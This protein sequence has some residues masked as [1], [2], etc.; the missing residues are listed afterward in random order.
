[1]K[2]NLNA[3]EINENSSGK[4][5]LNVCTNEEA[6]TILE[7]IRPTDIFSKE[8]EKWYSE[9]IKK[10]NMVARNEFIVKNLN[11]VYHVAKKFKNPE[12]YEDLVN[13]G[14]VGLIYAVDNF[15]PDIARFSTYAVKCISGY[16]YR[17]IENNSRL[18]R[19]PSY[20]HQRL[21][22]I[23]KVLNQLEQESEISSTEI[24]E[25]KISKIA[26]KTGY[27]KRKI[28]NAIKANY[29]IYSL[30]NEFGNE[31]ESEGIEFFPS[32]DNVEEKVIEKIM[33][34]NF[35][36][37]LKKLL[38]EI[39]S[40]QEK[41]IFYYRYFENLSYQNIALKLGI[42]KQYVQQIEKKAIKKIRNKNKKL[43]L[44]CDI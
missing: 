18:I 25:K 10:G 3:N 8:E 14:Y 19:I 40:K 17:Y 13:E 2:N 27:N 31:K 36:S 11:L 23:Y 35:M 43:K 24:D 15:D 9:E 21:K 1:M 37:E 34:E 42:S 44:L 4:D 6:K 7:E 20:L 26:E 12:L 28:K 16:M 5:W 29:K 41:E 32:K 38:N 33:N 30:N 22:K 39:L